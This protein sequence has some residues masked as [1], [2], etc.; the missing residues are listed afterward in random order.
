MNTLLKGVIVDSLEILKNF[1]T[2]VQ[3]QL[4]APATS[5]SSAKIAELEARLASYDELAKEAQTIMD[6]HSATVPPV[7][8]PAI[9][10]TLPTP[11][12]PAVEMAPV[13]ETIA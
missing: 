3:E 9:D 11:L 5:D 10:P 7:E 2:F 4:T 1:L 13:P 6:Q 12:E 8:P